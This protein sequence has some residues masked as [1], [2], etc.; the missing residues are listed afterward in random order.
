[1]SGIKGTRVREDGAESIF[2]VDGRQM[3]EP[4]QGLNVIRYKNG[5]I[6]KKVLR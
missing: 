3:A 2:S 1:M 5:A 6:K 4:R